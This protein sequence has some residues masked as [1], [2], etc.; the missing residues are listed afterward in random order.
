S[1]PR[2]S[3]NSTDKQPCDRKRCQFVDRRP[4]G[5]RRD[6]PT[7]CRGCKSPSGKE[8]SD[9]ILAS[10]LAE[11]HARCLV[12]RRPEVPVSRAME[13]RKADGSGCRLPRWKNAELE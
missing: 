10:R 11:G 9:C 2:G 8:H 5:V 6:K 12:E 3:S 7:C 13:L 4:T 1:A